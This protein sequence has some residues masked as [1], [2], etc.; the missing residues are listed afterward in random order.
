MSQSYLE[1]FSED[2]FSA[3]RKFL[4]TAQDLDL[5]VQSY[6]HPLSQDAEHELAT[7]VVVLGDQAAS[8]LLII[9]SGTHGLE[10]LAGSAI[11]TGLLQHLHGRIPDSLKLCFIHALNPW[12]VVHGRRQNEDN[13]DLNRNFIDFRRP[14]PRN[15]FYD[16][17]HEKICVPNL[18]VDGAVNPRVQQNISRFIEVRGAEAYHVALF[19]GQYL[20]AEGVGYGGARPTWSNETFFRIMASLKANTNRVAAIDI[21]TGLGDFGKAIL[22]NNSPEGSRAYALAKKWYGSDLVSIGKKGA[23]PYQTEGDTFSGFDRAFPDAIVVSAALE[24][25]TYPVEQLMQLQIEDNWVHHYSNVASP[26]GAMIKKKLWDFFYPKDAAWRQQIFEQAESTV[27]RLL[28]Q[29]T[30]VA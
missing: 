2:Y 17:L 28:W 27:S 29:L 20:H 9:N 25:G 3:R 21:H 6:G 16:L 13:V 30:E 23:L 15:L 1:Y 11:Q 14:R 5:P 8:N 7:D 26:T 19:Q 12:G 24:F 22:I 4:K 18:I 10:G